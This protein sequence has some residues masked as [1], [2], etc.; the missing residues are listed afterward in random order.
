MSKFL[1]AALLAFFSIAAHAQSE[2]SLFVTVR[3]EGWMIPHRIVAG[4]TVF[5]LARRYHVPPA[6]LAGANGL[7]YQSSLAENTIIYIP[8][9]A[10]NQ[11]KDKPAQMADVR[12]VY[13]K[14][15]GNDDLYRISKNSN[16][17]QHTMQQWNNLAGTAVETGQRLFVGWILYDATQASFPAR[18]QAGA[19]P[20][21]PPVMNGTQQQ[22]NETDAATPV[23]DTSK[24]VPASDLEATYMTQTNNEVNVTIEKGPAV[25]FDMPGGHGGNTFYAFHNI[26]PRG[27]IIKV[28]NPGN[29]KTVYVKVIGP[30][31]AA[32][33]YSNSIIGISGTA[34]AALG[35]E[36][37]KTWCELSFS[38]S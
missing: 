24:H 12:P 30:I 1:L 28:F 7:N 18:P 9:D 26:T 25:F 29:G 6:I 23:A 15:K 10:Y 38:G 11:V 35:V 36:D 3:G 34:K 32:K 21:P 20:A 22:A 37:S 31:P 5:M 19:A 14:A 17:Q 16:V 8:L 13:Y 4:E 33:L 2:D 27:T